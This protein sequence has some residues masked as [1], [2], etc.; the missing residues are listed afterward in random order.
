MAAPD[1]AAR[2]A[3]TRA[4]LQ[5][6]VDGQFREPP[7]A[8]PERGERAPQS[9]R[10]TWLL[11]LALLAGCLMLLVQ[12]LHSWKLEAQVEA[13]ASE[14]S[15]T[16]AALATAQATIGGYE[17]RLDELRGS[18]GELVTRVGALKTLV[19]GELPDPATAPT[20]PSSP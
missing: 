11:G 19:D 6:V 18:V 8:A 1:L 9:R 7:E 17:R 5:A 16:G 12:L 13:L 10:G 14:L 15:A 3:R 4:H 20:T 2:E